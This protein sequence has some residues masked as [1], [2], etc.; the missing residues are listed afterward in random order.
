MIVVSFI[1]YLL[2]RECSQAAGKGM[3]CSALRREGGVLL[4]PSSDKR[5]E[6]MKR[7]GLHVSSLLFY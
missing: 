1:L 2:I 7:G 6:Q 3:C 5:R 4:V